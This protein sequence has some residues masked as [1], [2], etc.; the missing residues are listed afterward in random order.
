MASARPPIQPLQ[1]D[2]QVTFHTPE[3]LHRLKDATYEILAG[4]GVRFPAATALDILAAH[5]CAVDAAAQ[6]VRFPREL[7]EKAMAQAPRHFTLGA[8]D[9]ACELPL[10]GK[11]T[12]CTT[13][14]CGVEVVDFETRER[15]PSTKAD[16]AHITRMVDYLP[17]LS[18]WWPTVS[19][20]DC[21]ETA[22]LHELE[23]GFRNTVKH[24][25]G[26]VMGARKAR[27]AVEM[28]TVIAG[29]EAELRRRP[30]LSDL[31]GTI[32][33]LL[34]DTD[35]IEAALVFA[36]AG[37]PVCFVTMPTLGTTAPATAAGAY[38]QGAAELVSATVLLQ[39]A[40]PGAPVLHSIMATT[41]DPRSGAVVSFPLDCRGRALASELA[42]AWGVPSEAAACGTDSALPGTWQAGMEEASDLPLAA[43]EGGDLMPS[44]GLVNVYTLFYPEH[45]ILDHD[46]YQ[47]ARYSIMDIE[48]DDESLALET[49]KAVGPGGHFLGQAHT[50][51]HMR[52]TTKPAI[53]HVPGPDGGFLDP[54][55][56]ARKRAELILRTY[57]PE[58][59]EPA[60]AAELAR[61]VAAADAE[62][63]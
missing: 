11:H 28:A 33:P 41:A 62:L 42:H 3:Q 46:I 60:K 15:R 30:P 48:I 12:Y 52:E 6:I 51:R 36:E 44:I 50:R 20:S 39:L 47:R 53:T 13:D 7:V 27:Y 22:Q 4:V 14:G 54:V 25:Q 9:P 31:I 32:S 10:D 1:R 19:A 38:A 18:F 55:E 26:M 34:Q 61:I 40:Y 2:F 24:L 21:G 35:G 23:A 43:L 5:G 45:M 63:R 17:G 49:V 8:R 56:A 29:S 57:E 37:V 59:L 16:L 58:P